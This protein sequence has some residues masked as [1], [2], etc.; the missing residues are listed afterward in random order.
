MRRQ[1]TLSR[2]VDF[3]QPRALYQKVFS[4]T[5]REHLVHNIKVHLRNAKSIEVKNRTSMIDPY[6]FLLYDA[7]HKLVL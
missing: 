6:N 4:E 3:E 2:A 7:D 1:L 5:D